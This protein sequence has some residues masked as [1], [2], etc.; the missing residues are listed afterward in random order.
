[1]ASST[2]ERIGEL[3]ASLAEASSSTERDELLERIGQL[4][5]TL[6]NETTARAERVAAAVE[7]EAARAE[8]IERIE[9]TERAR[10]EAMEA[11]EIRLA[12]ALAEVEDRSET[13]RG[14]LAGRVEGLETAGL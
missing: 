5:A 12:A 4:E 6:A 13:G 7:S 14:D 2:A 3:E 8:L 9:E 11:A 10:A 1:E